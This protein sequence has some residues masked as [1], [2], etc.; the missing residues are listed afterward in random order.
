MSR[1]LVLG[2]AGKRVAQAAARRERVSE[3]QSRLR[4]GLARLAA[5]TVVGLP[6]AACTAVDG[7]GNSPIAGSAGSAGLGGTGGGTLDCGPP[8]APAVEARLLTP[9]QYEHAV[10]DMLKVGDHPAQDFGGVVAG[11]LDTL[12]V[13]R[14]AK[15]AALIAAKAV[16]NLGS[17]SCVPP[18]VEEQT[19]GAQL[20]DKL[21]T[22]AFRRPLSADER[23]RLQQLLDAGRAEKDF[24][25]GV[26]W[27]LTALLQSPDFLYQFVRLKSG[28]VAGQVV[29]LDDYE[30]A[31]RLAFFAWDSSPDDALL[32]AAAAGK[33]T[34]VAQLGAELERI[35]AHP[36][37]IERG[38]P[39]F[40]SR[41]FELDSFKTVARD[42][43]QPDGS[44]T[45]V[46]GD[47]VAALKN[48]L[49][50]SATELY[51]SAAPNFNELFN[52]QSYYLNDQ[53][54]AFY[55]LAGG[56]PQFELTEL[57]NEGRRGILT[58]PALMTLLARPAES[59]PISRGVFLQELVLCNDIA[60]PPANLVIPPLPPVTPGQST[61]DR[62]AQ[63]TSAAVCMACHRLINPPGFALEA[64]D[65]VGRYRTLDQGH[66]V[67]T[68]GEMVSGTDVDGSFANG[69]ELLERLAASADAKRCFAEHYLEHAV[70]HELTDQDACSR[71][72]VAEAFAQSGDLKQLVVAVAKTDA[73]RLRATE[74]PEVTP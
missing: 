8:T 33:L 16:A 70:S 64:Y 61:R 15:A 71:S 74:T 12:G 62:L 18:A 43:L 31:S 59:F 69:S 10:E 17:W 32:A 22:A 40:Y 56:G 42:L 24:A 29:P 20:V 63:H 73:F 48:S 54:R 68:S 4:R 21:G 65:Q 44:V 11:K 55:G 66:P 13:E 50:M 37:F 2:H 41:W 6:L 52:G 46:P 25:T 60:P 14:R 36:R 38:A 1:Y 9:S 72:Q 51:R 26:D 57:P 58:H 35:L 47:L 3:A 39:A 19:C 34:D 5:V 23:G 30:I 49:L 45:Q 7:A 53:L 67:D 27:L 28:E